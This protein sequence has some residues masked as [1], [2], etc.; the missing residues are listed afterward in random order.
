MSAGPSAVDDGTAADRLDSWK[1]IAAFLGRDVRT[2][3]RWERLEGL[4]VHRHLHAE[5]GHVYAFRAE[6]TRWRDSRRPPEQAADTVRSR[7]YWP[8]VGAAVVIA[9]LGV[10]LPAMRVVRA[11]RAAVP[12][13]SLP[14]RSE[15]IRLLPAI[16]SE[17]ARAARFRVDPGPHVLAVTHD[18]R[19]LYVTSAAAASDG[20]SVV[21]LATGRTSSRLQATFASSLVLS[22]DGRHAYV[23]Q[24]GGGI[25]DVDTKTH[26][27]R[28]I[29]TGARVRDLALTPDG[30]RLFVPAESKGLLFADTATGRVES[31]SKL[32]CP[33]AV[34]LS[35]AGDRLHVNYQCGGPGGRDGHDAID[36]L[37]TASL[38]SVATLR[39]LPNVGGRLAMSPDGQFLWADGTNACVTSG[40]DHAGCPRIGAVV[41]VVRVAD[42]TL[43]GTL[44]VGKP[45]SLNTSSITVTPDGDRAI[46]GGTSFLEVYNTSTL[47]P[48]EA[49]DIAAFS[50]VA[51]APDGRTAYAALG[52]DG[53]EIVVIRLHDSGVPRSLVDRWTGDGTV[54][55]SFASRHATLHG[56]VRF[57]PGRVGR[58]FALD[59]RGSAIETS[60]RGALRLTANPFTLVL[61]IKPSPAPPSIAEVIVDQLE[62][63][64]GRSHG[65]RVSLDRTGHLVV[66]AGAESEATFTGRAT[67]ERGI[68]HQVALRW[69]NGALSL[70]V[71]GR[72]DGQGA[73]RADVTGPSGMLW[74]GSGTNRSASF[75]GIIDEIELY[76]RALTAE[77]IAARD[78]VVR[79]R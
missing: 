50:N 41:N 60:A 43:V 46:V 49:E 31:I 26:A 68:W 67:L 59:G 77:E 28:R 72:L 73:L 53:S 37:D 57:V 23:G 78:G 55:D 47:A 1:Q 61:S 44:A 27:V 32:A 5:R 79:P 29:E 7:R 6:I 21:D 19:E 66:D 20:L 76:E 40:Y 3:Q 35:P 33:M 58:A 14:P 4:P 69:E 54:T 39:E 71:D 10:I 8:L 38:A 15:P 56:G 52:G 64:D 30:K 11:R 62:L 65:V 9:L 74:I 13:A 63:R 70:F 17:G 24:S 75:A 42:R 34:A 45:D 36:V 51:F 48:V 18:G 25:L 16:T 2:V 22:P 12:I